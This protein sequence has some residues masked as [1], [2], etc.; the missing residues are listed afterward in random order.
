VHVFVH[1][2]AATEPQ[3]LADLDAA[4]HAEQRA[5]EAI[6]PGATPRDGA[7]VEIGIGFGAE[8]AKPAY[9]ELREVMAADRDFARQAGVF[10]AQTALALAH[11]PRR[12]QRGFDA[13]A[14]RYTLDC[15]MVQARMVTLGRA[16]TG[17]PS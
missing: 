3:A 4:G 17:A 6:A 8:L 9:A 14:F 2:L 12:S 15:L 11:D 10:I 13:E 5:P 16:A 1:R 7:M